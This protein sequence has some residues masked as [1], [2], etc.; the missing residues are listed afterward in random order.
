MP[1]AYVWGRALRKENAD[2]RSVVPY[3]ELLTMHIASMCFCIC[4]TL[5]PHPELWFTAKDTLWA[6]ILQIT[7]RSTGIKNSCCALHSQQNK[8]TISFELSTTFAKFTMHKQCHKRLQILFGF[9]FISSSI[10]LFTPLVKRWGSIESVGESYWFRSTVQ[11][12]SP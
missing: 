7:G 9:F 6:E 5:S 11:S 12:T 3:F 10:G 8:T 2:P 4:L 1:D